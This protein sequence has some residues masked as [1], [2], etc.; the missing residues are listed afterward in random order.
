VKN[1][2]EDIRNA[3]KVA[4]VRLWKIAERLKIND[5]NLSRKLRRELSEAEK[6]QIKAIIEDL[7]KEGY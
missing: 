4:G 1:T 5:G 2:N 7:V 3:A 6:M